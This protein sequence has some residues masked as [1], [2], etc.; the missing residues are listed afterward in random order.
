M[1]FIRDYSSINKG[2]IQQTQCRVLLKDMRSRDFLCVLGK[3]VFATS[4]FQKRRR[5]K[6][7]SGK[8]SKRIFFG[9]LK[10]ASFRFMANAA[11]TMPGVVERQA[12]SGFLA[13][14]LCTSE[15]RKPFCEK[16]HDG[17]MSFNRSLLVAD[18]FL[19]NK[20]L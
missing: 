16:K 12:E 2:K 11:N 9:P 6:C 17:S 15:V 18:A 7:V 13:Q 20:Q 3:A 14:N 4:E 19:G 10:G 8:K 5:Q 1:S